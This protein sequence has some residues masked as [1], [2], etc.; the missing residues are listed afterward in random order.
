MATQEQRHLDLIIGAR[1]LAAYVFN[2]ETKWKVDYRLRSELGLFKLR[3]FLCGRPT[4]IDA[5]ISSRE[6]AASTQS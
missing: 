4:T 5:R 3:G 6:E 1:A 2:D